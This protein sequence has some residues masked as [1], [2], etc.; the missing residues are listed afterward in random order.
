MRAKNI[1]TVF[2][3]VVIVIAVALYLKNR[4]AAQV[5]APSVSPSIE[6]QIENKFKGI[7]IPD[8]QEKIELKDVTGGVGMGIATRNEILA[9]LPTLPSGQ[10]Y[11][12]WL[13]KDGKAVLLGTLRIAKGGWILNYNSSIYP[14]YNKI[15][16]TQGNTHILEG[17]F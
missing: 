2:I 11:Q 10:F 8:D 16:V 3:I 6:E 9:D 12:G 17:S 5:L 15:I 4:K 1:F 7:T 14:G 13:E